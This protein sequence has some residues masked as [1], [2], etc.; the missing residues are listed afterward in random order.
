MK[1]SNIALIAAISLAGLVAA[2]NSATA[3]EKKRGMP[4]VQERLDRLTE[5]VKLTDEQK[6][7]V[8]AILEASSKKFEELSSSGASREERM[9]KRRTIMA[10]ESKKFKEVLTSEQYEKY[11]KIAAE[12]RGGPPGER[13]GEKKGDEKKE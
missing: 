5:S 1:I 12:R 4:S 6:P 10:E 9:E 11:E 7:K 8:K 13:K 3:Q 2:P